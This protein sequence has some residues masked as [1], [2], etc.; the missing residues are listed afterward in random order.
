MS[1]PQFG[2]KLEIEETDE[3]TQEFPQFGRKLQA[4]EE[5]TPKEEK[6]AKSFKFFGYQPKPETIKYLRRKAGVGLRGSLQ[7]LGVPGELAELGQRV[8]GVKKPIKLLPTTEDFGKIFDKTAGEDFTPQNTSEEFINRGMEFLTAAYSLGGLSKAPTA[9]EAF[10]KNLLNAFV[11]AGVSIGAEQ[12]NLPP[13]MQAAATIASSILTHKFTNKSLKDIERTWQKNAR[14]ALKDEMIDVGPIHNKVTSFIDEIKR[15]KLK[16][17]PSRQFLE[18]QAEGILEKTQ[19]RFLP[20][21]EWDGISQ[22]LGEVGREARE[23]KAGKKL[24]GQLQSIVQQGSDQLKRNNPKGYKAYRLANSLTRGMNETRFIEN[25]IR[26]NK[27]LAAHSGVFALFL[28]GA[29]GGGTLGKAA[30]GGVGLKG[31]EIAGSL[32]RN[33]GLRRAYFEIIKNAAEENTKGTLSALKKFNSQ[34]KKEGIEE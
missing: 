14:N 33:R 32:A 21:D 3:E 27:L 26:K 4:L 7:S 15:T 8:V 31:A 5:V 12:A 29:L 18:K 2:R 34:A 16:N 23:L 22:S 11:P 6:I 1:F 17:S 19:R 24:L 30:L 10:G 25:W 20:F 13:W 28:K 9:V